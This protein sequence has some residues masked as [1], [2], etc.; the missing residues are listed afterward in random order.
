M[1]CFNCESESS[2]ENYVCEKCGKP[3][4]KDSDR[5]FKE[6]MRAMMNGDA[7][8]SIKLLAECIKLN[9]L[10]AS[11]RYNLGLVLSMADR[12]DEAIE[13][14]SVVACEHPSYPGVYTALGQAAFGSYL[15]H[16]EEAEAK[17]EIMVE[18]LMKAIE[19]DPND[20]DA[21]FSLGNAYIATDSAD[22]AI[23]WLR[24]ALRLDPE[25]PAIYFT[26]A[27]A[28]KMLGNYNEAVIMAQ[29]SLQL[30]GPDDPFKGDVQQFLIDIQ[31]EA[32]AS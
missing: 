2:N 18:F 11:G 4:E 24:T 16:R 21:Y 29:K 1:Y 23:P 8:L 30:S 25:S 20:V 3:M 5:Y 10:H 27:R 14:Y 9:P 19:Q 22:K 26:I 28:F 12:C 31:G 6:A 32:L 17:R 15:V 7:V 13:Q